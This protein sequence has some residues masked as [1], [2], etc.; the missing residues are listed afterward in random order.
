MFSNGKCWTTSPKGSRHQ[1]RAH[2][3]WRVSEDRTWCCLNDGRRFTELVVFA[4]GPRQRICSSSGRDRKC[5]LRGWTQLGVV[6]GGWRFLDGQ[7]GLQYHL[8]LLDR[9]DIH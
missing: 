1:V 2:V 8:E 9:L 3:S 4:S 7:L 6:G 5:F